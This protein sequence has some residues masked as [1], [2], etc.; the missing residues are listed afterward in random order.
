M[1]DIQALTI[2]LAEDNEDHAE[3]I[4][5]TLQEFNIGNEVVHVTNGEEVM[6]YLHRRG[7][8][9]GRSNVDPDIVLLDLKM[10]RMNGK[11][12]LVEIRKSSRFS[13]VPVIMVSTSRN[14]EEIQACYQAGANS[15]ITKPLQFE[16]FTRKIRELNLY[17]VLTSELPRKRETL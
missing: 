15:Y 14:D 7:A 3:L 2:L 5:D 10:P 13:D 9:T 8:F 4:I 11:E 6:D 16:E 12:T 17:W 1:N